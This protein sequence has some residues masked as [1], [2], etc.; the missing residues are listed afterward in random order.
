[1]IFLSGSMWAQASSKKE[2]RI[3]HTQ[4]V[5]PLGGTQPST[6]DSNKTESINSNQKTVNANSNDIKTKNQ[7]RKIQKSRKENKRSAKTR[8][9]TS[10][11]RD[12]VR[13][14]QKKR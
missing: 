5:K 3:K 4:G 10:R 13:K 1:M 11:S 9:S 8:N 2:A 6:L 12:S 14:T 7:E